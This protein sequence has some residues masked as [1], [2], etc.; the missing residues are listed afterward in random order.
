MQIN[1][2]SLCLFHGYKVHH[3]IANILLHSSE[4]PQIKKKA[5]SSQTVNLVHTIMNKSC[6]LTDQK[7]IHFL[8]TKENLC[9]NVTDLTWINRPDDFSNNSYS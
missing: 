9:A 8:S 1:I 4:C 6:V 2:S 7:S 3:L 5:F